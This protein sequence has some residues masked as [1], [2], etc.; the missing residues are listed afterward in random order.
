MEPELAPSE[1]E[2]QMQIELEPTVLLRSMLMVV[3][4]LQLLLTALLGSELG[5]KLLVEEQ[6]SS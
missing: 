1:L 6:V 3:V 5:L 4:V 2:L